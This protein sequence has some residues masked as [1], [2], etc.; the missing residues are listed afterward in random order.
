MLLAAD[1]EL[2]L[3][4]VRGARQTCLRIASLHDHGRQHEALRGHCLVH[5]QHGGQGFDVQHHLSR[6]LARLHHGVGHHQADHL[7]DV[8]HRVQREDGLVV[9]E[10]GQD[11]V[12]GDVARQHHVAHAGHGQRGAS[13]HTFQAAVRH[14]RQDGRG[15]QRA[16]HFGDV[17]DVGRCARHL[18]GGA[19]M[20]AG[21]AAG[22]QG[23]DGATDG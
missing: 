10:G 1:L 22:G 5:R 12:A 21:G 14:R 18:G 3:Q 2:A 20:G 9:R 13:V 23:G 16:A 7:A 6:G 8:L 19:F 11:R 15:V 4:R 17:V